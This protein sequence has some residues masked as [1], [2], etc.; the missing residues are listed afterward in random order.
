MGPHSPAPRL[1]NHTQSL[2]RKAPTSLFRVFQA[3]PTKGF[4]G[5][6]CRMSGRTPKTGLLRQ[7]VLL[8]ERK[9]FVVVGV[10]AVACFLSLRSVFSPKAEQSF[11][12]RHSL[13]A[14]RTLCW[15]ILGSTISALAPCPHSRDRCTTLCPP[16]MVH[17]RVVQ[18][19]RRHCAFRSFVRRRLSTRRSWQHCESRTCRRSQCSGVLRE[20]LAYLRCSSY[21][22]LPRT[23]GPHSSAETCSHVQWQQAGTP[24][25]AL[26]C[27]VLLCAWGFA[28]TMLLW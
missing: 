27:G 5:T 28:L 11:E 21:A 15:K 4:L 12:L 26:P 19:R 25:A 3:L 20:V 16:P 14:G 7:W 1:H 18:T 24:A 8:P 10:L 13:T 23:T 6:K 17:M 9:K 22:H 2:G